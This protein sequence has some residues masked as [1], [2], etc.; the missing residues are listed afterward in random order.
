[1][2]NYMNDHNSSSKQQGFSLTELII[3]VAILVIMSTFIVMAFA[4]NKNEEKLTLASKSIIQYLQAARIKSQQVNIPCSVNINHESFTLS[5][6]FTDKQDQ[7]DEDKCQ[8][9]AD[10]DLME[11]IQG[12][13]INDLTICGSS[14]TSNTT[15]SCDNSLNG[16]GSDP[17]SSG[18]PRSLTTMV[19]TPRGTVS[20]GGLLKLHSETVGRTRCI[21]VTSP[22]GLIREGRSSGTD[23]NFNSF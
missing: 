3:V 16:D 14:D 22:I 23:C 17:D 9:L 15:M 21:A 8:S 7:D 18:S 4:R 12:L 1:M 10:I 20:Q 6:E 5:T 13:S 19:L 11:T 2:K